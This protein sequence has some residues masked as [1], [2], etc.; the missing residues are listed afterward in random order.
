[1]DEQCIKDY[2]YGCITDTTEKYRQFPILIYNKEKKIWTNGNQV[3]TFEYLGKVANHLF[4]KKNGGNYD[5]SNFH[6]AVDGAVSKDEN[7][8]GKRIGLD[9][10]SVVLTEEQLLNHVELFTKTYMYF[11]QFRPIDQ[12]VYLL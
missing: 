4:K 10:W 6:F 1:M 7:K 11:K 12:S 9:D 8:Y 2:I 3:G 5:K